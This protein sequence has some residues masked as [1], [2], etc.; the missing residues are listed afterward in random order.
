MGRF[1]LGS[2]LR[3]GLCRFHG[4]RRLRCGG[5]CRLVHRVMLSH[6][7][8]Q[9]IVRCLGL[10][11]LRRLGGLFCHN[12]LLMMKLFL[13]LGLFYLL[14]LLLTQML[15]YLSFLSPDRNKRERY[16]RIMDW[17]DYFK[18]LNPIS[19]EINFLNVSFKLSTEILFCSPLSRFLIVMSLFST[20]SPSTVMQNGVPISSFRAYRLPIEPDSS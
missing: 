4:P 5:V 9:S 6:L 18:S 7:L 16:I 17:L 10:R 13:E 1:R 3:R 8:S 19:L 20:E 14:L 2:T 15:E 12:R 11:S